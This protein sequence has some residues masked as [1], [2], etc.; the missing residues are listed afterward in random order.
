VVITVTVSDPQ[1]N[2]T[3]DSFVLTINSSLPV[4]TGQ[5]QNQIV[6]AAGTAT[7]QVMATSTTPLSYQWRRNGI[8]LSGKT[9]ATLTIANVQAADAGDYSVVVSNNR[10]SVISVAARLQLLNPPVITQ[11][12]RGVNSVAISFTTMSGPNYTVEYRDSFSI[13]GW[14][15]LITVSGT[16]NVMTI[17][18]LS[19]SAPSRFYQVRA[20]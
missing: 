14:T 15:P 18:D 17:N 7:F 19:A 1:G 9:N 20:Q 8:D 10:G 13:L 11:I 5:P 16:G 6:A 4:I 2:S 12:A 3:S